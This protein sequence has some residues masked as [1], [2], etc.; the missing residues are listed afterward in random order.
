MVMS[1]DQFETACKSLSQ[2]FGIVGVFGGNPTSHPK[3]GEICE[4]MRG[5]IPFERRGIWTNNLQGKGS[6]ARVT[7]NPKTSNLN[8]HMNSEA[9]AEFV[10]DWPE[11]VPYLKGLETDSVH[12]SPWVSM[13]DVGIPEDQRWDMI[14]SC[15]IN[16]WW[17]S[18]VGVFRGELR[19][20]FCEIAAHQ[21]MLHQDNPD[22][23]G[24]GRPIPD[25]GVKVEPNWWNQG[26][27]AFAHQVEEHCH[28][29][30]IP[31][32]REGQKA[33]GG[34]HEEFSRTHAFIARP[35]TRDRPVQMIESIGTVSRPERPATQ[36]L[37][38]VTPGY[39]GA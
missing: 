16:A 7:F 19:A 8:T 24:T 9:H 22:W 35:K 13:K 2:F 18:L 6:H 33:V 32:R 28:H 3:F 31:M 23:N 10:R 14:S 36:Y 1:V 17:S 5:V 38:L 20:W 11:S 37:P 4:V 25:T 29:C 21:S 12:S 34:T 15:D 39:K 27:G 30:G 26:M